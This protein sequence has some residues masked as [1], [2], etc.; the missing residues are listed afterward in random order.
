MIKYVFIVFLLVPLFLSAQVVDEFL[1]SKMNSTITL[2][3]STTTTL[4]GF[5]RYNTGSPVQVSLPSP[6]L[7][8]NVGDSVNIHFWND[9]PDDHT[10]HLHGLDVSQVNDGVP[11]TSFPVLPGDSTVYSFEATNPGVYLYHCH[12][13]TV[14]HLAMGMYGMLVVDYPGNLLYNG[15]PGYNKEYNYLS[16]ELDSRWN[17]NPT[18][19]G[20]FYKYTPNYFLVNGLSKDQ[21]LADSNQIITAD[22][23]DSVLIR[24]ANIGYIMVEYCF[25]P[26][27]NPTIYMSDGRVLPNA[28][29]LVDTLKIYPGERYS[30]L[31]RP[32]TVVHDFITVNAYDMYNKKLLGTNHIRI[33]EI[34]GPNRVEELVI[35]RLEIFPNPASD[36]ITIK[37]T[38]ENPEMIMVIDINGELVYKTTLREKSRV[39]NLDYLSD[40]VYILRSESGLAYKIIKI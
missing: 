39:I 27:S 5:G 18:S 1:V 25:P 31:L 12:V 16:S 9:S 17:D 10:I 8:Y 11:F 26:G 20:L 14:F 29:A 23:G 15:G 3:D 2:H 30:L 6:L 37:R 36:G 38:H 13:S 40:G 34:I 35:N 28:I 7:R 33:N 19:P 24:L 21:L 22:A 4:W 32:A